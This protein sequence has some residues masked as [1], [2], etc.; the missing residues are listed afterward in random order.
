M[1]GCWEI[2]S[3]RSAAA[4]AV[5]GVGDVTPL[6]SQQAGWQMKLGVAGEDN[7]GLRFVFVLERRLG[8]GS[9]ARQTLDF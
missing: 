6:V 3:Q 2:S 8:S 7:A 9:A 4:V 1:P 5:H